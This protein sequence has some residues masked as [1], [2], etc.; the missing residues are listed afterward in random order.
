MLLID[1]TEE[2]AEV[3]VSLNHYTEIISCLKLERVC[4]WHR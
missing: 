1:E 2:R 3:S 4:S